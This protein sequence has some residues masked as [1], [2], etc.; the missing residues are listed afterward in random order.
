MSELNGRPFLTHNENVST[1]EEMSPWTLR[2]ELGT[3][4]S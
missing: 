2:E 1:D 3:H 4:P